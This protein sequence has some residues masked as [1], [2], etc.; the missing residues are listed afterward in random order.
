[1]S[2]ISRPLDKIASFLLDLKKAD[3]VSKRYF[4][5]NDRQFYDIRQ[6]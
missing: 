3:D 2:S 5:L 4:V 1:M 6:K